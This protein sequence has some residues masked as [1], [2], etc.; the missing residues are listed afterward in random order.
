MANVLKPYGPNRQSVLRRGSAAFI[1][2]LHHLTPEDLF[3][4]QPVQLANR[5]VML[6][7]GRIDNRSELSDSLG[8]AT[9]ELQSMPD[10][11]IA[12]RLFDRWGSAR[13][14]GSSA[15]SQLS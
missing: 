14:R 9:P 11:M 1:V 2:C 12:L 5:F 3:E 7:D 4:R 6:F 15:I 8:I 10:S 13:S